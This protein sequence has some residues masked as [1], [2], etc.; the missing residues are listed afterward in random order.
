MDW[1][2]QRLNE[3]KRALVDALAQAEYYENTA[4]KTTTKWSSLKDEKLK[5]EIQTAASERAD[6]I[7]GKIIDRSPINISG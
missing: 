3:I 5:D 7:V 4:K 2:I 6:E 1:H